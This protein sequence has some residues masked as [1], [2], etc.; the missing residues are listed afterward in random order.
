MALPHSVVVCLQCV[1][2]VFPD[3]TH[4]LFL[5]N[6]ELSACGHKGPDEWYVNLMH[7]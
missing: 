6:H 2:V 7:K 1:T 3:H 5:M 4:L